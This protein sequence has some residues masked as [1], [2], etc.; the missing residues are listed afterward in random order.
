MIVGGYL[1]LFLVLAVGSAVLVVFATRASKGVRLFL[2]CLRWGLATGAVTGAL[3]GA[4]L[5]LI[6]SVGGGPGPVSPFMVG[7]L[8][9]GAIIGAVVAVIP[10]VIGAVFIRDMLMHRHPEPSS[11]E[12]VHRDLT[13]AFG[14]VVGALDVILVVVLV[15][16][17]AGGTDVSAAAF[18]FAAL[19]AGNGCVAVVLWRARTSISR[20][21][22]G[23]CHDPR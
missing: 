6:G 13:A 21:W 9:Y 14:V 11:E 22:I 2:R 15:A 8:V 23:I 1:G 17:M 18:S 4:S 16:V 20:L 12:S 10:T 5:P 19:L 7:G 3:F